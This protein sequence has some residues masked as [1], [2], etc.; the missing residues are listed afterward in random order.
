MKDGGPSRNRC[1]VSS[2]WVF[3]CDCQY[4][5]GH[6]HKDVLT[7]VTSGNSSHLLYWEWFVPDWDDHYSNQC[8]LVHNRLGILA[9]G[10]EFQ[11]SEYSILMVVIAIKCCLL[12]V[13]DGREVPASGS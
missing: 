12:P 5:W 8:S 7:T 10:D 11:D 1:V 4:T 13:R 2:V 6:S 9:M 3:K